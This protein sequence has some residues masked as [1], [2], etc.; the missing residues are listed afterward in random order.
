MALYEGNYLKLNAL[1]A[2]LADRSGCFLS[3]SSKDCDLRLVIESM[4]RYTCLMRLTYLFDEP[5]GVVEDPNLCAKVYFDARMAEVR[6]WASHHRH[7][8]LRSLDSR[9]R[10][11]LDRRWSRNMML[12]KWL[13]YLLD[14]GHRFPAQAT[15]LR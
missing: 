3:Y 13:D 5:D 9:Y 11:E 12:S 14:M 15:S 7:E 1:I 8:I 2:E 6:S 4:T 10:R